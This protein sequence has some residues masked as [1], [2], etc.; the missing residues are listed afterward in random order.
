MLA[1]DCMTGRESPLP[2]I[3]GFFG[4][5][6]KFGQDVGG[7]LVSSG[8]QASQLV[9][10][11]AFLREFDELVDGVGASG[12]GEAAEFIHVAVFGRLFDKL[13]DAVLIAVSADAHHG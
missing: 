11:L 3:V 6:G 5:F 8:R 2:W 7:V 9:D 12:C 13:A 10:V 1:G 4:L